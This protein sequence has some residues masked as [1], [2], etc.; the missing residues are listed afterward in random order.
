MSLIDRAYDREAAAIARICFSEEELTRITREAER[1]RTQIQ[2]LR[3]IVDEAA[4]R[5]TRDVTG[6]PTAS[7]T[8][9]VA[10]GDLAQVSERMAEHM[11]ELVKQDFGGKAAHLEAVRTGGDQCLR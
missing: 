8:T 6:D 3:M 11:A 9:K 5:A 4:L 2:S 1:A 10:R 7:M